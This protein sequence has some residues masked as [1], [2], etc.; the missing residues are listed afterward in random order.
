MRG[1][2][3]TGTRKASKSNSVI[4]PS[5]VLEVRTT[6]PYSLR[7][8]PKGAR[9]EIKSRVR[10]IYGSS[11]PKDIATQIA[12]RNLLAALEEEPNA[13]SEDASEAAGAAAG[14]AAAVAAFPNAS[15]QVVAHAAVAGA[16][17]GVADANAEM[18]AL[19]RGVGNM[20]VARVGFHGGSRRRRTR[21]HR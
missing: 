9:P 11:A 12:M 20:R 14:A 7:S 21:R 5:R 3:K 6:N 4:K 15:P 16:A 17:A 13:P 18:N 1:G 2:A 8:G 10:Q 19:I